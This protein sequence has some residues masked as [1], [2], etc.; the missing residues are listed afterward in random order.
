MGPVML[1][2][3]SHLAHGSESSEPQT[4]LTCVF[5]GLQHTGSGDQRAEI[6]PT[7]MKAALHSIPSPP[8]AEMGRSQATAEGDLLS[9]VSHHVVTLAEPLTCPRLRHSSCKARCD[10]RDL[11]SKGSSC[12]PEPL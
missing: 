4:H 2:Q 7:T 1:V 6:I 11:A 5:S 10:R 9:P 3:G 12:R 8:H